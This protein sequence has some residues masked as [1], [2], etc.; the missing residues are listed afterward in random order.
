LI[1]SLLTVVQDVCAAVGVARPTTVFGSINANRTMQEMLALANEFAQRIACDN[2]EWGRL[3]RSGTFAGDGIAEAFD[4]P[5]NFKR[6]LLTSQ[7]WRSTSTMHP[8]LFVPDTDEWLQRRAANR[9][10]GSG[11][12]TIHGGQMH[13][14][15]IMGVGT[16]ARFTYLDKNCIA[17]VTGVGDA[18]LA[19][20]DTFVLDERLLKLGMI[21]QWK[22]L[23]GSP[24]AEDMANY[25]D[26][27]T[28]VAGADRP[29]PIIIGRT[30]VSAWAKTAYPFDS[31]GW[32]PPL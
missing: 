22:A 16:S 18:F 4:L 31:S 3:K 12:W 23:K 25:Q 10:Y 13:I 5:A 30:P 14:W 28:R 21:W 1:V 7:V 17:L 19:D 8:M 9:S 15:P 20:G 24:Y 6:M 29:A 32:G 26:A 2:R 27:L 11:E